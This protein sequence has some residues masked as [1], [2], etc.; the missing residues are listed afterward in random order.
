MK[1]A[2]RKAKSFAMIS[3]EWRVCHNWKAVRK[4]Q[5]SWDGILEI[6]MAATRVAASA[7]VRWRKLEN[8]KLQYNCGI[9]TKMLN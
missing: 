9:K 6:E 3:L 1:L 2:E 5:R 7:T 8:S 4:L